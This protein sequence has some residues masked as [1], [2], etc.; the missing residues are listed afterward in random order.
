MKSTR[1]PLVHTP[2]HL[3]ACI[4]Y[5]EEPRTLPCI[6]PHVSVLGCELSVNYHQPA[7]PNSKCPSVEA[8]F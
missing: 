1:S 5:L 2:T 6:H 7:E 8:Q 4:W 3:H